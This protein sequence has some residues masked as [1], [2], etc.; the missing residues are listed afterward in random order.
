[1]SRGSPAATAEPAA[2]WSANG[3]VRPRTRPPL[4][5][6][7]YVVA[8][9]GRAGQ[10]AAAA[11]TRVAG[12]ARVA[13]WDEHEPDRLAATRE[14]LRAIGVRVWIGDIPGPLA[15]E[16][17]PL[18]LVKSPGFFLDHPLIAAARERGVMV[19]DETELGWRLGSSPAIGVTGTNGKSTVAHLVACCLRAA[20]QPA[21]VTGN[22]EQG[23]PY[24]L[25]DGPSGGWV[26]CEASSAGL[27]AS[28]A[29]LPE[30]AV[31]TNL[32]RDHLHRHGDMEAYGNCKRMMFVR[33]ESCA[34]LAVL[35]ADD[36]FGRRLAAEVSGRGGS[37]VTYGSQPGAAY[38]VEAVRWDARFGS[39]E[40]ETPGGVVSIESRLP[41][42]HNALN[43]T[44][45]LALSDGLGLERE[46]VLDALSTTRGV[47]GRFE[48]I[49]E[50]QRFDAIVD[51]A[52][53]PDAIRA[54][55]LTARR[56]LRD[57]PRGRLVVVASSA[58]GC[59]PGK[60][61]AMGEAVSELADVSIIT[62]SHT[63][64]ESSQSLIEQMLRGARR[65]AGGRV[66]TE[67]VRRRAIRRAVELAGP[68]DMI[69]V[70]GRGAM[71]RL[72]ITAQGDGPA[73]DDR[74]VLR[75]ALGELR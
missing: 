11:L 43:V 16:P 33:G 9:L 41:G 15:A 21:L 1:V 37:V 74:E 4:P 32:T 59:D 7:P 73:F 54:T 24:S 39:M 50:G 44:A 66:E 29:F 75:G 25:I 64:G 70:L 72:E 42:P 14:G 60:R 51:L 67:P 31:L 71:E 45:A 52:H 28:P 57:R 49:E 48:A 13:V 23:T 68:D 65:D 27:E 38:R 58:A 18:C 56:I 53:T 30:A 47:P 46:P 20:G 22:F 6:G 34:P 12:A 3:G 61:P 2:P 40:I 35:N 8:G 17:A 19:L 26:V 69:L 63:R 62:T 36:S 10:A 55:L 5:P